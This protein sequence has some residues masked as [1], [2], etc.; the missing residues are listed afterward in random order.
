MFTSSRQIGD[1]RE[2]IAQIKY[3]QKIA[4]TVYYAALRPSGSYGNDQH[5]R[6]RTRLFSLDRR[7]SCGAFGQARTEN[8]V[9]YLER[10]SDLMRR[11]RQRND[12]E[13]FAKFGYLVRQIIAGSAQ[14]YGIW[15]AAWETS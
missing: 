3:R 11:K 1:K 4:F 14:R 12:T 2:N 15:G 6:R 13:N 7:R 5:S 9:R 8:G 10:V